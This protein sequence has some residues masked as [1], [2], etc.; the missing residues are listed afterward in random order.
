MGRRFF[1]VLV[2]IGYLIIFASMTGG[3]FSIYEDGL[4]DALKV[5]GAVLLLSPLP[6]FLLL[7]LQYIIFS[8]VSPVFIFDEKTFAWKII[9]ISIVFFI[10]SL[11]LFMVPHIARAGHT[12]AAT[13]TIKVLLI[14]GIVYIW[15]ARSA[16]KDKRS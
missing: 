6:L 2:I 13:G 12:S 9:K 11:I 7:I 1:K 3:V 14:G 4:D 16:K 15:I 8:S 5:I 10:I